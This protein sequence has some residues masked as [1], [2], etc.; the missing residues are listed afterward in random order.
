MVRDQHTLVKFFIFFKDKENILSS[1]TDGRGSTNLGEF[2]YL[3][4]SYSRTCVRRIER[5]HKFGV[6]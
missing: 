1:M 2:F 3:D 6:W 4:P 5:V